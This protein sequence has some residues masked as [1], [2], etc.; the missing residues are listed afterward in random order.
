[1]RISPRTAICAT[2]WRVHADDSSVRFEELREL[3]ALADDKTSLAL[4]IMGPMSVH[5]QQGEVF[6]AQRLASELIA[7]LDSINDPALTAEAAFGAIGIKFQAGEMDEVTRLAQTTID[8][9]DGDVTKGSLVVGS[10]LAVALG[11]RGC[12]SAWFGRP[13]WRQDLDNAMTFAEESKEPLTLAM[14]CSWNFGRGRDERNDSRP[15]MPSVD[16]RTCAA[17]HRIIGRQLRSRHGQ[18]LAGLHVAATRRAGDASR[19]VEL[20]TEVRDHCVRV[21]ILNSELADLSTVYLDANGSDAA[22]L[23]PASAVIRKSLDDMTRWSQTGYYIPAPAVWS[24]RCWSVARTVT[25]P[26]PSPSSP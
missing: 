23:T 13:G 8:W 5:A 20:L 9:A 6:K 22:T 12:A 14:T 3:C 19:G 26:R 24:N 4:A 2:D 15:T 11:L 17:R 10:P 25:W 16:D 18:V 21:R 7:L 1:M